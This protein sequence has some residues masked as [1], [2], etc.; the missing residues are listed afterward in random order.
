[1]SNSIFCWALCKFFFLVFLGAKR[2]C[3]V[4]S[5]HCVR[6]FSIHVFFNEDFLL[7]GEAAVILLQMGPELNVSQLGFCTTWC[8]C[9]LLWALGQ[10]CRR[11]LLRSSLL[12]GWHIF[13]L[14]QSEALVGRVSLLAPQ[15][16]TRYPLRIDF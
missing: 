16:T 6:W 3:G 12:G 10:C 14:M 11:A 1:M 7:T 13:L 4:F 5:R 8:C 2:N 9:P 15:L